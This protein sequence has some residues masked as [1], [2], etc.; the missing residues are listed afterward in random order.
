MN[1]T[2]ALIALARAFEDAGLPY[3][4]VGSYSSNFYGVPRS[5]KD[6][7]LVI[8]LEQADWKRL[9]SLLPTGLELEQQ[10]GF[11]MVTS[12]RKELIRVKDSVFEIELFHLSKDAHDKARFARRHKVPFIPGAEAWLPTA[13]R[14]SSS[15]NS[16]GAAEPSVP[17]T[18]PMSS[19]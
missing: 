3:M 17:R 13:E 2:D 10:S 19:R 8:N 11:E 16:A 9:S 14:T 18:S 15:R 7:D 12:T 4:I 6:A 5:T 1:G